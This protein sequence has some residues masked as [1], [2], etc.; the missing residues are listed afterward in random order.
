MKIF[1]KVR[2]IL[3]ALLAF[4]K[5]DSME[6]KLIILS[7]LFVKM[8]GKKFIVDGEQIIP[9]I[10]FEFHNLERIIVNKDC[11]HQ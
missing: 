2:R 11:I 8:Q 6:K 4:F 7:F 10:K 5:F 1:S 9:Y 3:L